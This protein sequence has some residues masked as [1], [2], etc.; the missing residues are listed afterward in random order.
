MRRHMSG[1]LAMV[2]QRNWICW[3]VVRSQKP[4]PYSSDRS[5]NRRNWRALVAPHVMRTR[6]MKLPGVCLR[7]NRPCHLKRFLSSSVISCQLLCSA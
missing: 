2:N 5:A 7:K 4:L 3:R 1:T 6:S